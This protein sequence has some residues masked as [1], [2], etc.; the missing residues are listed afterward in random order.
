ME[1]SL[2]VTIAIFLAV[3]TGALIWCLATLVQGQKDHGYRIEQL[4]KATFR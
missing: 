3:Q 4:E 2:L 1:L